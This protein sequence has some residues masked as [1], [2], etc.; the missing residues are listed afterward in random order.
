[1]AQAT[2]L[3][4]DGTG[5]F[6][7]RTPAGPDW[8]RPLAARNA[9]PIDLDGDGRLDLVITDGDYGHRRKRTSR[10]YAM[11]QSAPWQFEDVTAA[12]RLPMEATP[13]NGLAIGDVNDDGMLD[14]FVADANRLFVS[15]PHRTFRECEGEFIGPRFARGDAMTC[16]AVFG[17]LNGDGRL[18]LVTTVHGQ[19]G[20]IDIYLNRGVNDGLPAFHRVTEAMGL[21][22]PF[23]TRGVDG[24]AIKAAHLAI[25]D[26]DNDGRNDLFLAMVYRDQD[27]RP[28]PVVLRNLGADHDGLP[29]FSPP[30]LDRLIVYF[31]QAPVADYDGDGRLDVFFPTWFAE[32]PSRLMRNATRSETRWLQVKVQGQGGTFNR[33]GIGATVRIYQAGGAGDAGRFLGRSDITLGNGYSS[34]ELAA[35]HFGLGTVEVCDVVVQ[36]QGRRQV[37]EGVKADRQVTVVFSAD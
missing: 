17:D 10:L 23:P 1:M 11:R 12:R 25:Q 8:P 7:D 20:Q 19:P 5:R 4:N 31:A 27:G 14:I 33:Q 28:Q 22:A 29:R 32:F 34:G 3:E 24:L 16:G 37:L 13:G 35:A 6:T 26:F 18:D 2:L 21:Q 9:A 36:W 15:T 30:P